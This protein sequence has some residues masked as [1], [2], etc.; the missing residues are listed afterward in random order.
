MY[1]NVY[2]C[3]IHCDLRM[4]VSEES[5]YLAI[6]NF[7]SQITSLAQCVPENDKAPP[8]S[9]AQVQVKCKYTR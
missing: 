3:Y 8:G 5:M 4:Q 1:R 2:V 6:G 7:S 9:R